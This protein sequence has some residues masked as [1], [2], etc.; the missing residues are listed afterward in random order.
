MKRNTAFKERTAET[1]E[2][3]PEIWRRRSR[4][5]FLLFGASAL[6]VLAV[7]RSWRHEC[8]LAN[9]ALRFDDNVAEALYSPS[10]LVPTYTKSQ[11]TPLKNNYNGAT[12]GPGYIPT[13]RLTLD[14][15]SSRRYHFARYP[16]S[17]HAPSNP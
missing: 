8:W 11:I 6:G 10:R 13:W 9:K 5:D 3:T 15:L 14:G 16:D 4:R 7:G 2:V 12:P 1:I 17:S